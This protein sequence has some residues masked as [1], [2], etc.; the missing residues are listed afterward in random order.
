MGHATDSASVGKKP[1]NMNAIAT[2]SY[3]TVPMEG[4]SKMSPRSSLRIA[5]CPPEF[6]QL[7]K[8]MR[9][10]PTDA[11]YI[12]Q[13]YIVRGLQARGH[14][15]TFVAPRNLYE[16]VCTDDLER[17]TLAPRTWSTSRWFDLT[18]KASWRM[19]SWLGV[20]YLNVFSSYRHFDACLQCLPGHDVV[21][22]RNS[23]YRTGVAMACKR[24][25]LPYVLFVEADEIL[26][27]DYMGEPITGMQRWRAK[28]MFQYNLDAADCVICVSE[29]SKN[30]LV[31]NWA[32]SAEKVF[33]SPNA[34]DVERFRPYPES[35]AQVRASLKVG[36]RP[37][38]IFVGNF[39]EWHDVGTL[40]D[41]FA[42]VLASYP[43]IRL[44]LVGDGTQHQ[45]MTQRAADLG[46]GHAVQFT[47]YVSHAEIP[48]FMSAADI[49]VAPYPAMDH[50]LWLSPLKLFEYMATDTAVVASAVGQ[51]TEVVKD[52]SNGLLVAP[53]DVRALSAALEKLIVDT[54][55]RVRL[56]QQA[57]EDMVQRYSWAQYVS[58]LEDLFARVIAG[59]PVNLA[60][61][62]VG[63]DGIWAVGEGHS[64]VSESRQATRGIVGTG[65]YT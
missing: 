8:E 7:Q 63:G 24:L 56:G 11:T 33:V 13:G 62:R 18:S 51:P 3:I 38:V 42:Q 49:A 10:E 26:E 65:N 54:D 59:Q 5:M 29:Q 44:V 57:R 45:A 55:L 52:G 50:E 35:R 53:G 58:R 12:L 34:V 6:Q 43:D 14:S 19:Q 37:M 64:L 41:A 17:P 40:L 4:R 61:P 21:Y 22:E 25:K 27:H 23:L 20:P 15:L 31:T 60:Q 47:G 28:S 39:Y 1:S 16:T 36:D 48:R 46:I 30:H 9:G 32:V 2:E